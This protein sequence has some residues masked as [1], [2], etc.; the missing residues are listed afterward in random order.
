MVTAQHINAWVDHKTKYIY[1]VANY[2]INNI[3]S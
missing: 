1:A 3:S 2:N